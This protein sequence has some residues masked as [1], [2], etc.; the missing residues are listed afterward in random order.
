MK[1][2]IAYNL[3]GKDKEVLE[4]IRDEIAEKFEV[5]EALNFPPHLTIF[6]PFD[7]DEKM[8]G[9][10]KNELSKVSKEVPCFGIKTAGFSY[11]DQAVWYVDVEQKR[12]LMD[13]KDCLVKI[14]SEKFSIV[15]DGKRG[16]HFHVTVAYKDLTVEKFKLIGKFLADQKLE[17]ETLEINSISLLKLNEGKW[18]EMAKF[19]L[20]SNS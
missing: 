3:E 2:F 6:P 9:E 7:A 12:E 15:P 5:K 16:T 14:M 18:L 17:I 8:L 4:V 13:L 11:F 1:Y 20:A 19:K 10:L